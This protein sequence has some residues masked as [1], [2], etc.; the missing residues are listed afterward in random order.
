M[1][2]Y[3]NSL[4]LETNIVKPVVRSVF[5][6]MIEQRLTPGLNVKRLASQNVSFKFHDKIVIPRIKY[7]CMCAYVMGPKVYSVKENF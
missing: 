5:N 6:I 7:V 2:S 4:C 1:S 3:L